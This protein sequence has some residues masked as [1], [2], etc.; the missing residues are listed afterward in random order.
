MLAGVELLVDTGATDSCIRPDVARV[1][2]LPVTGSKHMHGFGSSAI[3]Q[4]VTGILVL[5]SEE[6]SEIK[7]VPLIVADIEVPMIF[8][9]SEIAQGTLVVD[10]VKARWRWSLP[11]SRGP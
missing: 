5:P 1:L 10:G 7:H 2:G 9:M 8:G 3:C 4:V 11:G 6:R